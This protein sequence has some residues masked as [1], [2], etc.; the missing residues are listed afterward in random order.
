MKSF[1]V[2]FIGFGNMGCALGLGLNSKGYNVMYSELEDKKIDSIKYVDSKTLLNECKYVFLALKPYQY[3]EFLSNNDVSSNIII[4]IAAGITSD[5]MKRFCNKYILTMPNTPAMLNMGYSALVCNDTLTN[6]E[7]NEIKAMFSSVGEIKAIEEEM[8]S[9][10][11][12]LS[13]S[14]PAYF[15]NF[16]DSLS[17]AI[18]DLGIDKKEAQKVFANV[19]KASAQMILD[20]DEDAS[21][22][23]NNVCS[24]NGTTI[25]AVTT[26]KE[27]D[28]D[29]ICTKA[30]KKCYDRANEMKIK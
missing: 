8:L 4:S 24:P 27:S 18:Q 5:F 26:F 25:E 3:E 7:F 14:S 6:E 22:L 20:S 15:F 19:M 2:G 9:S 10:Y 13:G 30:L 28:L 21:K 16:I 11:I 12:C 23:C 1:S 29:E 17:T